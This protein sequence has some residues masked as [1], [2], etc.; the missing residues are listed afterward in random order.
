MVTFNCLYIA[1]NS[2]PKPLS[3]DLNRLLAAAKSR[4]E[5]DED[6]SSAISLLSSVL[7]H[8]PSDLRFLSSAIPA[9]RR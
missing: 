1:A 9:Y 5:R 7:R 8:L 4:F 6:G 2:V 3:S